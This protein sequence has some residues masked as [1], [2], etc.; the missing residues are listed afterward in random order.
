MID[1]RLKTFVS[2]AENLSFSEAAKELH[3]SQ[4]A[5][6]K[7][8]RE[9]EGE[10]GAV[11]FERLGN[12]I[13]LTA[14]GAVLLDR[15]KGI[16]EEYKKMDTE[17][18]AIGGR[19]A[20]ELRIAA[21]TTIAQYVLPQMLAGFR[22]RF[23]D[24]GVVML[25]GNSRE[26]ESALLSGHADIGLAE[27][28]MRRAG[29]KYTPFLEDELV[30]IASTSSALGRRECLSAEELR[31]VPL[32]LRE[33]GSGTLDVIRRSLAEAGLSLSDLNVEMS[34]GSTE[35]IK[36]YVRHSDALGLVSIRSVSDD[37]YRNVFRIIDLEGFR[38]TREFVI[39]E[40]MGESVGPALRFKD[41]ITSGYSQ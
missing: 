24:I 3:I 38:M 11:L 26:V 15:A 9:L 30:A 36:N 29:L 16:L 31:S 20:G 19:T 34:I 5:V 13:R 21:S 28:V 2:V 40:R 4:P 41:F 37:I 32:V 17:M 33:H 35:G 18:K 25:S 12:R 14:A 1:I 23:P 27:G 6:S 22:K 7:H 39:V 10:Y 8:V